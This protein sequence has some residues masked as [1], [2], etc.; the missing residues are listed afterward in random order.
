[1]KSVEP[2][3]VIAYPTDSR[4]IEPEMA[5]NRVYN[6]LKFLKN[7]NIKLY[8]KRIDSTFRGNI[9]AE[10]DAMLDMLG[11][12]YITILVPSF[13]SAGR[14]C[15]GG[16]L[17]VNG[18]LLQASDAA[19]DPKKPV[20]TS[21]VKEL[22]QVQTKRKVGL[23]KIDIVAKGA[24]AVADNI[25]AEVGNGCEI[26]IIDSITDE[27]I[28]TVAQGA[29]NSKVAFISS[30]PGPF[31]AAVLQKIAVPAMEPMDN[32]ILLSVGSITN[33]TRMQ[34]DYLNETK[35][36]YIA[37]LDVNKLLEGKSSYENEIQKIYKQINDNIE[38]V[39]YIAIMLSSINPDRRVDFASAA[40]K[41]NCDPEE[42]SIYVNNAIAEITIKL[43]EN[44][45]SIKGV[46]SSGGDIT[47]AI[48]KMLNASGLNLISEVVPLAAYGKIVGG[49]IPG[50]NIVTKGGMVGDQ[51]TAAFCADYLL[52]RIQ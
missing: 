15:C 39:K 19:K 4:G 11:P 29:I 26:I 7:E 38:N 10:I 31:T 8:A 30:D 17:M 43:L 9:G 40:L 46:Y 22:L 14:I 20:N 36:A 33:T 27:D 1:M 48:C 23:I 24:E 47:V 50:L 37:Y 25:K 44:H 21:K 16:Y 41:M 52:S 13:P 32:K 2:Y 5:Y 42:I 51:T 45:P 18:K 34:M 6:S 12:G 49:K 35:K 28:D 3:D